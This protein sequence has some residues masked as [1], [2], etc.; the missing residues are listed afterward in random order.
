MESKSK[1]SLGIIIPMFNEQFICGQCVEKVVAVIKKLPLPTKL[2]V[3][4]DG[5][6][7]Q[8]N[9]IL[10]EKQKK[11]PKY[12]TVI[13]HKKNKG[14]GA[15]TRT[16]IKE[17]LK[18]KF[19]WMLHMDSDLTNDP[20]Y[21]P[22]FLRNASP[23][24]DCIKASRYIKGSQIKN[25]TLLRRIISIVGNYAAYLL[26]D[27]GIKDCTNGFRMVRSEKVRGLRFKE[28]NFSIILEELYYLK[29]GKA[30]FNEIPYILT[31]RKNSH[32]HFSYKP[33]VFFDYF[34]YALLSFF[35]F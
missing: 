25:V 19:T 11:Y 7:D 26:F 15:A 16:G 4:N 14:Y 17:A 24:V 12:L 21:I 9:S 20:K 23:N 6:T 28:N 5:S 27:V 30:K 2:I 29:R 18:Q 1:Q 22:V 31:A 32:S 8:T 33:K 13:S 10:A 35:T 34:K 3:V